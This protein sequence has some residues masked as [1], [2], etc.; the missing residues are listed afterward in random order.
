[1]VVY[2][3]EGDI[4]SIEAGVDIAIRIYFIRFIRIAE[5]FT[6]LQQFSIILNTLTKFTL[7]FFFTMVN[8]YTLF[9]TYA[10]WGEYIWGGKI[11]TKSQ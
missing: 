4:P 10:Y 11:T 2:F 5:F 7:P 6:E 1:M 3:Y 9:Y 8:L